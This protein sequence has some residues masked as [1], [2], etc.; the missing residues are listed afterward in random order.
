[1]R[2]LLIFMGLLLVVVEPALAINGNTVAIRSS[3][4]S[5]GSAW[6][7]NDNGYLGTYVTLASAGDVTV[8]V[9]AGGAA[10][11]SINPQMNLVMADEKASFEVTAG[12]TLTYQHTFSLPAGTHFLR[13]EF[14]ND[15]TQTARNLV[16]NTLDVSGAGSLSNSS[17]NANALNAA[18]TY[19]QNFRQGPA[20][21][22]LIGVAPG[23]EV[24]VRLKQHAFN[25]GTAVGGSNSINTYLGNGTHSNNFKA[26]LVETRMNALVPENAGKWVSNASTSTSVNMSQ[27]DQMLN[28][29][30]S[31]DLRVRMHNLIWGSQQPNWVNTL[32]TNALNSNPAISGP[33]KATLRQEIS[34]RIDYYV[35]DGDAN[36]N[37]GDRARRWYDLDVLNEIVHE[38]EYRDI[39]GYTDLAE[40]HAEV[41]S[42]IAAAGSTAR[43]AANEYNVLQDD[44]S[45]FFGNWYRREIEKLNTTTHGQVVNSIGIQSYENNE[46]GTGGGAHN[47]AR[48]MNTLQNLSILGLPITLTE[49][50]VKDPTSETDART[51]MEETMRIVFGT[52]QADGF[53]MW[54]IFRGDIYRGAAALYRADWSLSPAGERW[55]DLMTTDNDGDP[56][57]DWDTNLSTLVNPDGTIDFT[58]FYGEYEIEVN[59]EI[60]TLDLTKGEQDYSLIVDIPPDFNNDDRVDDEDLAIWEGGYGLTNA[61]DADDDGDTDGSDFLVW[62]QWAGFGVEPLAA[63]VSVP[64]P[65]SFV[66]ATGLGVAMLGGRRR[67]KRRGAHALSGNARTT[68]R[69]ATY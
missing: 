55:I 36:T 61:G 68:T 4:S 14:P 24:D 46:F 41:A 15:P 17:T 48:K 67:Q 63:T 32:L 5:T 37:D 52:P 49:F 39:F 47:P 22:Q 64:E 27:V 54:G 10:F 8:S 30:E 1:M 16:I 9:Q 21:V 3:G 42:A 25:F 11:D 33:A 53:F 18:N 65:G 31:E 35:G 29:A 45:D 57:D 51:M 38:P 34:E 43:L 28:Y 58:G 2:L 66:L 59:G 19:I 44:F 56:L 69:S 40:I 6:R 62:Q 7:L 23:T 26:A 13:A 12:S 20:N 50:G 60:F